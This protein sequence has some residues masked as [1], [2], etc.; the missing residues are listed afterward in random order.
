MNP[1]T[2]EEAHKR[3]QR[4]TVQNKALWKF[5]E[6]LSE[7]LN[8]AGYDMK[9]TLKHDVDIPWT[10]QSIHDHIWV[11]VQEAMTGK[12]STTEMNTVDPSEIYEVVSRYLGQRTGVY[13]PWPSN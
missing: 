6:M 3:K 4:T 13:V 11:P 2:Q 10:K 5:F 1:I 7:S 8:A 12:D 9:R